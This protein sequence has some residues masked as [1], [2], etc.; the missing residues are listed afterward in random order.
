MNFNIYY[1][2]K[3]VTFLT[4]NHCLCFQWTFLFL[5]VPLCL[6]KR[7]LSQCKKNCCARL[8]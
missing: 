5:A 3:V 7:K 2:F 6:N 8:F 1:G 4:A